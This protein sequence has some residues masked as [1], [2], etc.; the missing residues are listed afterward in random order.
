MKPIVSLRENIIGEIR[1]LA[2]DADVAT[3][4]RRTY[5]QQYYAS[6]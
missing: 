1:R 6:A 2:K 4:R 5:Q 3:F